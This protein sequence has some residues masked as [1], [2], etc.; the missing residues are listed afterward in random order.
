[1][2]EINLLKTDN[3]GRVTLP[4]AFRKEPLFEYVIEG[5]QTILYPVRTVR[6][7]PDLSDLPGENLPPAWEQK[8]QKVNKD[9]RKGIRAASA[10]DALKRLGK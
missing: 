4:P 5:E 7:Y 9:T 6:K 10:S 3:R 8:E 1:M 2:S